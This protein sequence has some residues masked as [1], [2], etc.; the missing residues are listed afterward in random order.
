MIHSATFAVWNIQTD[1]NC[2]IETSRRTLLPDSELDC[3]S[4][5]VLLFDEQDYQC[6]KRSTMNH[7]L[8]RDN[9]TCD[10][11]IDETQRRTENFFPLGG[12]PPGVNASE[13]A[14][15]CRLDNTGRICDG[16]SQCLTDECG[17]KNSD[18]D[19]FYCA[20]GSGC[21][22]WDKLCDSVQNCKDG[23]DECSCPDHLVFFSAEISQWVCFSEMHYCNHIA[24][25]SRGTDYSSVFIETP[26]TLK[27]VNC[28]DGMQ[29]EVIAT[30]TA[31]S[32][33]ALCHKFLQNISEFDL[34]EVT[35]ELCHINCTQFDGF[36][37][38]WARFCSNILAGIRKFPYDFFCDGT[39]LSQSL[40]LLAVCDGKTDCSNGAD[41]FGCPLPDRFHCDPNVTA[42]WVHIDKVCDSVKDC[43]NGA[44]ECGTCQFEALSSSEFLIQS[45]I[46]V[47]AASIMGILIIFL[48]VREGCNCWKTD[49]SSKNK[50]IDRIF[51]LQIFLYDGLMGLYLCSIVIAAMVLKFKGDYCLLEQDW[52]ASSFCPALGVVFSLSSHGSLLAIASV[53]ISRFLTCHSLV[54]EIRMKAVIVVSIIGALLNLFHSLLPLIPINAI[55]D[56]FRS[57]IFL[58]N[59]NEN[60]FFS[61]SVP[62]Q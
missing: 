31:T 19:V 24:Q 33:I 45:K 53:S 5:T 30:S 3:S 59:L 47:A 34:T 7:T 20:D 6:V 9:Q 29:E 10:F 56:A 32:P 40:P 54:A 17:C 13:I 15:S 25:Q 2:R 46:I 41:E 61:S 36:S 4:E 38:G 42:E 39:D 27:R 12:L 62:T 1:L 11:N 26:D 23:S 60:P 57:A 18:A 44:D 58:E 16:Y 22:T 51:L 43:S 50:A 35:P 21:V 52:R 48:N 55:Q 14:W 8:K 28:S 49:C 37:D